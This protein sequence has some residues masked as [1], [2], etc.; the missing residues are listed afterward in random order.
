V[1]EFTTV[2]VSLL[3]GDRLLLSLSLL[4]RFLGLTSSKGSTRSIVRKRA[5]Q[6]GH[7]FSVEAHVSMHSKQKRWVHPE[8][9]AS[10]CSEGGQSRQMGQVKSDRDSSVFKLAIGGESLSSS[11]SMGWSLP[12]MLLVG[13]VWRRLG[14]RAR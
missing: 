13:G 12:P 9:V 6:Q 1:R 8:I 11:S 14:R 2:D 4:L 5:L 10:C 7:R 3:R